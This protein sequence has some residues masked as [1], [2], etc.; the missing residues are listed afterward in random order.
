MVP[1]TVNEMKAWCGKTSYQRGEKY[2]QERRVTA[3]THHGQGRFEG[4]VAG[5]GSKVYTVQASILQSGGVQAMCSCPAAASYYGYC[6]HVAAVLITI[7][8]LYQGKTTIRSNWNVQTS[9][10][11]DQIVASSLISLFQQNKA[12]SKE[13]Q[14]ALDPRVNPV[15]ARIPLQVMF[16]CKVIQSFGHTS[17]LV[18]ELKLGADRLYVVQNIG[19]FLTCLESGQSYSFT[20]NFSYQPDLHLFQPEDLK[21]LTLCLKCYQ[22]EV[23]YDD[24]QD[25]SSGRSRSYSKKRN[26]R[27]LVISPLVWNDLAQQLSK[28]NVQ[29]VIEIVEGNLL[30]FTMIEAKLPVSFVLSYN[31]VENKY[32]LCCQNL[33]RCQLLTLYQCIV[34][35]EGISVLSPEQMKLV[36]ELYQLLIDKQ[37]EELVIPN[38]QIETFMSYVIPQLGQLC[39]CDIQSGVREQITT[40]KLIAKLFLDQDVNGLH[41][42]LEFHYGNYCIDPWLS[43][44]QRESNDGVIIIRDMEAETTI[45]DLFHAS[46]FIAEAGEFIAIRDEH[47]YEILFQFVPQLRDSYDFVEVYTTPAVKRMYYK[48]IHPPKLKIDH[49]NHHGWL[50]VSFE[51]EALTEEERHQIV[52]SMLEKKKYYRLPEGAFLSLESPEFQSFQETYNQLGVSIETVKQAQGSSINVAMS[53]VFQ[54]DF[55]PDEDGSAFITY[56]DALQNMLHQLHNPDTLDLQPPASITYPLR[57]YQVRGFR[58]MSVLGKYGLGGILA[59]DMGLG[60]TLQSIAFVV[61]RMEHS[62]GNTAQNTAQKTLI[63]AP[64]SLIYNWAE[65]FGKFAPHIPVEVIAGDKTNRE[66][67]IKHDGTASVWITTYHTLRLDIEL[68]EG[69]QLDSLILDEAQAIKNASSQTA[70]ALRKLTANC[71][72][73]LTGTPIENKLEDM[74]SIFHIVS[75]ALLGSRRRF[76]DLSSEKISKRVAPFIL[77]RLKRDVLQEL[78]DRIDST[79][80]TELYREQK[81]LYQAYLAKLQADTTSDLNQGGF[82]A[83]RIKILAG[84]TRLRQIC[85]HPSLFIDDY[86]GGSSKLEQLLELVEEACA[87]GKRILIFSQFTSMLKIIANALEQQEM[88]HFYL[89]GSTP[90]KE[91]ISLCHRFN[92]GER[93]VFLISLK[94]GGTGLNL[95]GAD[96]VILYDLWWNPAV[97]EQA[98]GRAHRMGQKHVVQVIRLVTKGTVEEKILAL[99]ERKRTLMNEVV[100][101]ES[102]ESMDLMDSTD[103]TDSM[104]SLNSRDSMNSLSTMTTITEE[105]VRSLLMI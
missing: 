99:Q 28:P 96:T 9:Y 29:A 71:S 51:C 80:H 82:Q 50:E 81:R 48:P 35:D 47:I 75:P 27:Q 74:W 40:Q 15:Q 90:S 64:A 55:K 69:I 22:S 3:L 63:V 19:E 23:I 31:E 62:V 70:Q 6:K 92:E 17:K 44:D 91:R 14:T 84:I 65:E 53:S 97:E 7:H 39:H 98:A 49:S 24:V 34:S 20:K 46:P 77:R 38:D 10:Q 52:L 33:D 18:I 57:D 87:S 21:L 26:Q 42:K 67:I 25:R 16:I 88:E 4:T 60:K 32:T 105:D 5:T 72:F 94:A 11:G 36:Y 102:A 13:Q 41:G 56:G 2:V 83:H 12:Q 73:A 79:M 93:S 30:P 100:S 45:K 43:S 76:L 59:D 66:A 89:D 78:P 86:E 54:Q 61:S 95:T 103:S 37:N 101:A 104:N 58:F 85:C 68:Y 8:K 1:F